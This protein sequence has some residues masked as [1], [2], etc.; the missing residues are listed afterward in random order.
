MRCDTPEKQF[1]GSENGAIISMY[2]MVES[3]IV[4]H[5]DFTVCNYK[6]RGADSLLHF[7]LE[8]AKVLESKG[9]PFSKYMFPNGNFT[10]NGAD[11][12][13]DK[14]QPRRSASCAVALV[15]NSNLT[16]KSTSSSDPTHILLSCG[17]FDDCVKIHS[18]E[19]LQLQ[20]NLRGCHRGG[21][22]CLEVGGD[23]ETLVTGGDDA[24][25]RIWIVDHDTLALAITDGFV[26]SSLS[27]ERSDETKCFHVHTLL[28]H[29]TPVC[30]V[31]VCIK[32]DIV[33]SGSQGGSICIHKVRSGKFIRAFHFD[34]ISKEL[35]ESSGVGNGIPVKKLSI[36]MGGTFLAHLSDGSLHHI[37]VNGQQL[38][39]VV[40]GESLNAMIICQKSE[41]VI[42]GGDFGCVRIWNLRDLSLQCTVDVTK[43]GSIT[44]LVL[45]P[46]T[47]QFLCVGSSNGLMSIVSRIP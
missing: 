20:C 36:H 40:I 11:T 27:Q 17:Y 23:G 31:A 39:S 15:S 26:K 47:P 46:G 21:I 45:T 22:N 1:G 35:Q 33:V 3:V 24:T 19:S 4:I 14:C 42:S 44:S 6:L 13:G 37:S 25:C 8:R 16:G 18:L 32:L 10:I 34:A 12:F 41:T 28:G 38:C 2:A 29:I 5:S 7:K 30:C 43:H 9:A